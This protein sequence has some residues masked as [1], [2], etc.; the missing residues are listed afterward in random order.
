MYVKAYRA[1]RGSFPIRLFLEPE[2]TS[3]NK[4]DKRMKH[5]LRS[6]IEIAEIAVEQGF[7]PEADTMERTEYRMYPTTSF[8]SLEI[9][10]TSSS[11]L[12]GPTDAYVRNLRIRVHDK[13]EIFQTTRT[14]VFY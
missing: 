11:G 14:S 5:M 8:A 1:G 4:N 2:M 7:G 10:D 3:P 9:C 13:Q 6:M 12:L